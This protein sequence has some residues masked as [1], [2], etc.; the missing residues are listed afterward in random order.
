MNFLVSI[1]SKITTVNNSKSSKM[2]FSVVL[3][4]LFC[5][6]HLTMPLWKANSDPIHHLRGFGGFVLNVCI[7]EWYGLCRRKKLV[8]T[9]PDHN[10]QLAEL[11][12][13]SLSS[14]P[15]LGAGRSPYVQCGQ[16]TND[17]FPSNSGSVL[18]HWHSGRLCNV[19]SMEPT[20]L[21]AKPSD[22]RSSCPGPQVT[23]SIVRN[24]GKIHSPLG[25]SKHTAQ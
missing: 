25:I 21:C 16:S 3:W 7:T 23:Q 6:E 5:R 1:S 12:A 10:F 24:V 20:F 4:K 18:T 8:V 9:A 14:V 11:A 15:C 22:E 17:W 13:V 19:R 2:S